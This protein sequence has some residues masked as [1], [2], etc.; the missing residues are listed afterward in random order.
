MSLR[1]ARRPLARAL[2][3]AA[4]VA[5]GLLTPAAHAAPPPPPPFPQ[6]PAV[7]LDTSCQV[8][9]WI[10]PAGAVTVLTDPAQGPYDGADDT[11]VGVQNDSPFFVPYLDLASPS[12]PI[13]GFDGDGL[14]AATPAPVGCPFGPTG[15]EGPGTSFSNISPDNRR[16]RVNFAPPGA[17]ACAAGLPPLGAAYFSLE[18]DVSSAGLVGSLGGQG[19]AYALGATVPPLLPPTTVSDTG[20]V[21]TDTHVAA[22]S[23]PPL[24]GI[25]AA[26]LTGDV[27]FG[28]PIDAR[29]E[30]STA[31]VDVNV[32]G[33][34]TLNARVVRAW[35]ETTCTPAAG[36]ASTGGSSLADLAVAVPGHTLSVTAGMP[37]NTTYSL[38]PATLVLNEQVPT[39]TGLL[40]NAIHLT[41]PGQGID[42]VVSSAESGA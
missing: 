28:P 18:E 5:A 3:A 8:L 40:V 6:C 31:R 14:C 41:V 20:Y 15:Y 33:V 39:A 9:I 1:P 2:A 11:L 10:D 16:G 32:P 38:G 24:P 22:V 37:P 42:V 36:L 17:P 30:A 25:A 23:T 35:S 27:T 19:R 12:L 4:V 13:F 29:A 7:G 21:Y 34:V 26:A